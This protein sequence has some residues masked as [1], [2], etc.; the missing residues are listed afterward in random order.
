METTI[1]LFG[2]FLSACAYSAQ[3][4]AKKCYDELKLIREELQKRG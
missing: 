4:W 2:L 3:Y 1:G